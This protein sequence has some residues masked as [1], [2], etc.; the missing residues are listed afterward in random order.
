M[1]EAQILYRILLVEVQSPAK[2]HDALPCSQQWAQ[3]VK[4]AKN[5]ATS[6]Y[7]TK[8]MAHI[9]QFYTV[10]HKKCDTIFDYNFG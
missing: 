3:A 7:N 5:F 6:K 10:N 8:Y 2:L 4:I 1:E 9:A